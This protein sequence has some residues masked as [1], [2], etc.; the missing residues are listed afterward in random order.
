MLKYKHAHFLRLCTS[1]RLVNSSKLLTYLKIK[2]DSNVNS[3]TDAQ[4]FQVYPEIFIGNA[5]VKMR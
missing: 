4:I 5:F 2:L 1:E 3:L